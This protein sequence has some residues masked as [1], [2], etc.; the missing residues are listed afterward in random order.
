LIGC[1]WTGNTQKEKKNQIDWSDINSKK[2]TWRRHRAR[3][4]QL[5][6]GL[7][8]IGTSILLVTHHESDV[9]PC[10]T[11]VLKLAHGAVTYSG[12]VQRQ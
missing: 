12:P 11:H 10:I 5:L 8:H 3:L 9:L 4:K 7:A 6:G 2:E 1:Y